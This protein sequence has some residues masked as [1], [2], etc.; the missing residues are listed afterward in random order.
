M[1]KKPVIKHKLHDLPGLSLTKPWITPFTVQDN[2][3]NWLIERPLFR[4]ARVHREHA[5]QEAE[6]LNVG[7]Q[8]AMLDILAERP[9]AM[10]M[11]MQLKAEKEKIEKQVE[12][13]VF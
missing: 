9:E 7:Y 8:I 12:G 11:L 10:A 13:V 2:N 3:G 6:M 5:E 1:A 4:W